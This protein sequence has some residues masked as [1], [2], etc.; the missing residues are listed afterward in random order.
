MAGA[1]LRLPLKTLQKAQKRLT[2][3]PRFLFFT[4]LSPDAFGSK[5]DI[6]NFLSRMPLLSKIYSSKMDTLDE[7]SDI[8]VGNR[9]TCSEIIIVNFVLFFYFITASKVCIHS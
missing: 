6:W 4:S 8:Q 1:V 7:T 5:Q 3:I 9:E 2:F